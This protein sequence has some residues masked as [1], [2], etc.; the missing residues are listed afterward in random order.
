MAIS[1][2][3]M[4]NKRVKR[5]H[6]LTFLINTYCTTLHQPH[7]FVKKCSGCFL[8]NLYSSLQHIYLA[9]SHIWP[10]SGP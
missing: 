10:I 4:I 1:T 9:Q 8:Y 6:F 3:R 7:S 5:I 2:P